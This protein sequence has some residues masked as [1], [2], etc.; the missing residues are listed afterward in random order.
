[1]TNN[2]SVPSVF[3]FLLSIKSYTSLPVD[4]FQT[5]GLN[6]DLLQASSL[7]LEAIKITVAGT[8]LGHSKLRTVLKSIVSQD[9]VSF[10]LRFN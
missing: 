5:K 7:E 1:M 8:R 4:L 9:N 10:Q 6:V 3:I 2:S